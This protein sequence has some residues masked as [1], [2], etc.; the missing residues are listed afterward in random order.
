MK[1]IFSDIHPK[2]F[3]FLDIEEYLWMLR[4]MI[5]WSGSDNQNQEEAELASQR[6]WLSVEARVIK[7]SR[8]KN[9]V[10]Y[11]ENLCCINLK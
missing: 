11:R 6:S 5:S 10:S 7:V 4:L 3:H 2:Y 8:H 1:Q 9:S